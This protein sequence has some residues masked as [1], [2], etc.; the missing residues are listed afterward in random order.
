MTHTI[1]L[2]T[3]ADAAQC[4]AIY[5]PYVNATAVSFEMEAPSAEA[6]AGR[7]ENT[8]QRFPWLVCEAGGDVLGYAYAGPHRQRAAFQWAVE[9]SVYVEDGSHRRGVGRALYTSLF[10]CLRVLGYFK[11]YAVIALPNDASVGLH[12]AVGFRH[13]GTFADVGYKLGR[14]H[15][16][17]YWELSLQPPSPPRDPT[18]LPDAVDTSEWRDALAAGEALLR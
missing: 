7:I 1:R 6:V 12:E 18:P 5:G 13:V 11:A 15:P 8:L 2:A 4:A 14:W 10:A 17:G 16:V 3:V 9:V